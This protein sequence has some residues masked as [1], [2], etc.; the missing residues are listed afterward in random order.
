MQNSYNKKRA[1]MRNHDRSLF[2]RCQTFVMVKVHVR[3]E[4]ILYFVSVHDLR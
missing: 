2:M 3:P 4:F 1:V